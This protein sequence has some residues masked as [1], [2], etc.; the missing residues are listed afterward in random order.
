MLSEQRRGT[1]MAKSWDNRMRVMIGHTFRLPIL[2]LF[3]AVATS[4]IAQE[5]PSKPTASA[6]QRG[7][8]GAGVLGLLPADAVSEHTLEAGATRLAYTA[9]AGTLSLYDQTGTRTGA[10]FYTAYVLKGA[11]PDT[12]PVTFAFNGGPGAASAYLHLGLVGPK[13]LDFGP[14]GRD[15]ANA[16]LRD[17]PDTWLP[18][19]DLI[20]IDPIGTGWSRTA[21]PEDGSHFW[22][23]RQDAQVLA[24]TIAL[25]VNRNGRTTSPKYILGESYGGFR[26]VKV[27]RALQND[28]GIVV[29]GI[30]ALSPLLEGALQYGSNRFALGAALQ[31]PSLAA[32]EL[33]RRHAFTM[34]ALAE[35]ERFALTDYLTGLA[36]PPL[37]GEAARTFYSRVAQIAGLPVE[38][39]ARSRGFIR[40]AYI[41]HLRAAD[42]QVVSAYDAT[43]AAPDPFPEAD[44]ARGDDPVLDGFTRAYGGAMAG[45]A[46]NELGFKTEMT[47]VLLARD[48]NGKWDWHSD[49]SNLQPPSA[50]S[51]IR[52]LLALNPS[53]KLLVAHGVTD[54]V[55]PYAVNRYVLDHLPNVGAGERV[56]LKLYHGGHMFYTIPSSRAAFAADAKALYGA[57]SQ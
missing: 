29:S 27:A 15:G 28:Q 1:Y 53:F 6:E 51:D 42:R 32:T 37:Q 21:K 50:V 57:P 31:L 48:I 43:L 41:K 46:R 38:V 55:I 23:V 2:V 49:G 36:G 7:A 5:D 11:A 16:Q 9:T 4:A 34:E 8:R 3:I 52:E 24:K 13:I 44:A 18:F 54:I 56:A 20:L 12:R 47:Y 26:A 33:E 30:I 25:Y 19:T 40:D 17:N 39:V 22:G 35:A 10:V 45:Y 14:D